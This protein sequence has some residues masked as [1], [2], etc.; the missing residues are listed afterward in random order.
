MKREKKSSSPQKLS[1]PFPHIFSFQSIFMRGREILS[2]VRKADLAHRDRCCTT[3]IYSIAIRHPD[4]VIR[5]VCSYQPPHQKFA[6]EIQREVTN[7]ISQW[8]DREHVLTPANSSNFYDTSLEKCGDRKH[9]SQWTIGKTCAHIDPLV[10]DFQR[11][12]REMKG[13]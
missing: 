6:P 5:K 4:G 13:S 8:E 11:K 9:T 7:S 3:E 10:K 12:S 1:L 2:Y